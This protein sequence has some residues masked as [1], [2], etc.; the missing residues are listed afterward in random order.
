MLLH[1]YLILKS[2]SDAQSAHIDSFVPASDL[3]TVSVNTAGTLHTLN[4]S[5]DPDFYR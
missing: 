5:F 3:L 2:D 1:P 4:T